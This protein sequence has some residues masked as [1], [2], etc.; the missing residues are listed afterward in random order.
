MLENLTILHKFCIIGSKIPKIVTDSG[1]WNILEAWH[2]SW[3]WWH[4]RSWP[5]P[6]P[7]Q[8]AQKTRAS[9]R[10]LEVERCWGPGSTCFL[11]RK[12]PTSH[13]KWWAAREM[14]MG[15]S[16]SQPSHPQT[17]PSFGSEYAHWNAHRGPRS[18][19]LGCLGLSRVRL[20]GAE[21]WTLALVTGSPRRFAWK[22][23]SGKP[24]STTHAHLF[25]EVGSCKINIRFRRVRTC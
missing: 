20:P 14:A 2:P 16:A 17:S 6:G 1:S 18:S 7:D 11:G 13:G 4:T 3:N 10:Q 12:D 25:A 15:E 24:P 5:S 9:P 23:P 19:T 22:T 8:S 21:W